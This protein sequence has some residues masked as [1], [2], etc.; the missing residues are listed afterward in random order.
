MANN[1]HK[2]VPLVFALHLHIPSREKALKDIPNLTYKQKLLVLEKKSLL[3]KMVL[4]L[5][6]DFSL[7]KSFRKF[8][9][10]ERFPTKCFTVDKVTTTNTFRFFSSYMRPVA[11]PMHRENPSVS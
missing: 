4:C 8:A 5:L 3:G 9:H 7:L 11:A 2:I 10:R 6:L 1:I